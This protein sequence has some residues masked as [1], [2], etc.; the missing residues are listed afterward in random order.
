VV[1]VT[2]SNVL[3]RVFGGDSHDFQYV[4]GSNV[5]APISV[6]EPSKLVALSAMSLVGLG[7]VFF[8]HRW[9]MSA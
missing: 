3:G 6:P 2:N 8:F 1:S 9:A 4:S 5:T 7:G